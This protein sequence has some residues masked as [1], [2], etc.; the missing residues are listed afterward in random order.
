MKTNKT[1]AVKKAELQTKENLLKSVRGQRA[2]E[3]HAKRNHLVTPWG[4]LGRATK[5]KWITRAEIALQSE[6]PAPVKEIPKTPGQLAYEDFGGLDWDRLR[7]VDKASWEHIAGRREEQDAAK[8]DRTPKI[9]K[10]P[11]QLHYESV[12]AGSVAWPYWEDL[13]ILDQKYWEHIAERMEKNTK[14]PGQIAYEESVSVDEWDDRV[15][16]MRDELTPGE[17]ESWE[18]EAKN[19]KTEAEQMRDTLRPKED[20]PENK[21]EGNKTRVRV[22]FQFNIQMNDDAPQSMKGMHEICV[23]ME[24]L[25][26]AVKNIASVVAEV[27]SGIAN[28]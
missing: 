18:R 9:E 13:A 5:Q 4:A 8:K 17:M 6:T 2:Y 23:T 22:D 19:M 28:K 24:N 14:T 10:T 16:M 26:Y 25:Q 11:G 27:A 21:G 15:P 7:V 3:Q 20:E 1:A 12:W